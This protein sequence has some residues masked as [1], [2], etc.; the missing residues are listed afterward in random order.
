MHI[1]GIETSCDETAAAVVEGRR[2]QI[3]VLANVVA[4][5]IKI[6]QQFGGVVPEVAAREHTQAI[7]P[8]IKKALL[9]AKLNPRQPK[10]D[11]IAATVG[12]G[13]ITSLLVGVETARA[14]SF[15]WDKPLAAVNHIA[16][17]IYASFIDYGAK[18]SW[19]AIILTVSGG[20]TLLALMLGHGQWR[21]IGQTRDDAAGEAFDKAAKLLGLGYPGG[22]AISQKAAQAPAGQI[23]PLPRPMLA[24]NNFDFS[25]SGL[26]T[27]L[28]YRLR[29]DKDWPDKI[30]AYCLEFEQAIVDVLVGKTIAAAQKFK[31]RSIILTGGVAANQRLR[32]QLRLKAK[33]Q[34]PS[35]QLF[36]T[37]LKYCTDNAAM[38][39]AAGYYQARLNRLI[40]YKDLKANPQLKI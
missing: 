24:A 8:V 10:L 25:F 4:S 3:F 35:A 21:I 33:E 28:L 22:P 23:E 5:Q 40:S 17:H 37:P 14:L 27:A 38:I 1:L 13:L 11:V 30:P 29:T 16:G 20:H 26:K 19:P 12:P 39:A 6:H 9:R 7:L 34:L 36:I 15:A 32:R 18:I 2:G 31:A